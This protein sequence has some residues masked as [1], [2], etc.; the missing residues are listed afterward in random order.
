VHRYTMI[1]LA[2]SLAVAALVLSGCPQSQPGNDIG[3]I[4]PVDTPQ[5]GEAMPTDPGT[6]PDPSVPA[7]AG[8]RAPDFNLPMAGGGEATLADYQGKILVIDFW[9]T[10]CGGCIKELPAY[11]AMYDSWDHEKVDYIGMSLDTR[12]EIIEAFVE[13][14]GYTLP[15]ALIDQ[16][17]QTAYLGDG[18]ARI[19]EARIIDG[20]GVLR[21]V[22]G[23]ADSSAE[24]VGQIV[25][26]MLAE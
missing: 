16:E 23:P 26:E 3:T 25:D 14:K 10:S 4:T 22:L 9:S 5:P 7:E 13:R 8:Q 20:D 11:Q 18:V 6:A 1:A 19:P 2:V 21:A 17:T 12:V 15:M 24:K